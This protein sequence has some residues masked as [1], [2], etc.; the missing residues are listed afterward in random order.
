[1]KIKCTLLIAAVAA[2]AL[3]G[4]GSSKKPAINSDKIT[5]KVENKDANQSPLATLKKAIY[6]EPTDNTETIRITTNKLQQTLVQSLNSAMDK[7][8]QT[9]TSK[10]LPNGSY[11]VMAD[12]GISSKK[13][14][15]ATKNSLEQHAKPGQTITVTYECTSLLKNSSKKL[16]K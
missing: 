15:M 6:G 8:N 9:L 12:M 10:S 5:I 7:E 13:M 2:F 14:C 1:M 11:M 16:T 4:C 3:T